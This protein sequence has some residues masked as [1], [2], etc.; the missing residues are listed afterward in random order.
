[1]F[2]ESEMN[3]I[4]SLFMLFSFMSCDDEGEFVYYD[5]PPVQAKFSETFN[6]LSLIRDKK[7]DILWVID[8]SGS[9]GPIQSNIEINSALFMRAFEKNKH[10]E[11]KMG[12]VSTDKTELPYL[13][14]SKAIP[15]DNTSPDPVATF[16]SAVSRLGTSGSATEMT[17]YNVDRFISVPSRQGQEDY[18]HFFRKDAHLVVIMVTDEKEQS[19][20]IDSVKYKAPAFLNYIRGF[21]EQ[22][23]VVRFYGAFDFKDLAGCRGTGLSDSYKGS[24][25]EEIIEDTQGFAISACK[26]SFGIELA[27]VGDDIVSLLKTPS[28]PLSERPKKGTIKVYFQGEELK[29]G[30]RGDENT[31][32]EERG[33]WTY[34]RSNSSIDFYNLD[35]AGG[36]LEEADIDVEFEIDDGV[37][38]DEE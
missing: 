7:I 22:D 33:I 6:I 4:L 29:G 11:W 2:K 10:I 14:F 35:F 16:Q 37:D 8:N 26:S 9:M 5:N 1:M 38:R 12:L 36:D 15:F 34:N 19:Y 17:F 20:G 18:S 21:K 13:G 24:Q 25:F 3:K 28:L 32:E 23:Q 30:P 31:P 27:R